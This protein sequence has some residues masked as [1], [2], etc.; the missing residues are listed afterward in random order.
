[1]A[2]FPETDWQTL[3]A[4]KPILLDRLC[5]NI[6]D[7]CRDEIDSGKGTAHAR[8][9]RLFDLIDRR[10]EELADAFD[11]MRRS[12]AIERLAHMRKL[13]LFTEEEFQRLSP[14]TRD[15][16]DAIVGHFR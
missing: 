5:T 13:R 3:R 2:D 11:D 7:D 4:L 14:G 16:V 6:L 12:R 15:T 10:N 9:L 1:M 8:Y